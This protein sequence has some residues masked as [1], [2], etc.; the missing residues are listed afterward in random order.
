M[1]RTLSPESSREPSETG[2]GSAVALKEFT[3][4]NFSNA[5]HPHT[6][7]LRHPGSQPAGGVGA[8]LAVE[9]TRHHGHLNIED[10]VGPRKGVLGARDKTAVSTGVQGRGRTAGPL[11]R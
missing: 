3:P 5:T 4:I 1:A 10:A 9:L 2:A 7:P 8:G 11:L 6:S